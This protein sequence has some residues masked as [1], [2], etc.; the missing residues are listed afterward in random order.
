MFLVCGEALFDMFVHTSDTDGLSLE[1]VPGGSPFNVALGLARLGQRAEFFSSLSDDV[2]GRKL[3]R[4]IEGE[5]VG[6]RHSRRSSTPTTLG[7][8]ELNAAGSADYAFYGTVAMRAAI[9]PVE[10]PALE[11][12]IRVIHL[13]SIAAVLG[14]G[15]PALATLVE[16]EHDRR[17]I[18]YDPNVRATIEPDLDIWR[19][20]L[21][22]LSGAA[23]LIK[24]S[25][26]D[27]ALLYPGHSHEAIAG[28]WLQ[29][30]AR[31]VVITRGAGGAAAWTRRAK[32][33]IPG[34]SV[35][36]VDTVGAGDSFQ[37]ALLAGLAEM[38][39]LTPDAL[40]ELA[41]EKLSRLL[42]FAGQAATLTCGRR[43]ADL[44]RRDAIGIAPEV[45]RSP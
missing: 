22:R 3:V 20:A 8:V 28:R 25:S 27:L 30:A 36:V 41:P 6:L 24:V 35:T 9:T 38:G 1:A 17:L 12:E 45:L 2:M 5:G 40:D 21:G 11:N 32:A 18:S 16:R 29:K 14:P 7:I 39:C 34:A 44:P 10:L 43:G 37:A 15:A 4:F 19:A 23:H 26:D 31:L 33:E 13:G 42:D